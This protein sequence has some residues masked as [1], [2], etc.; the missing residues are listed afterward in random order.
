M[1]DCQSLL[2]ARKAASVSLSIC[3]THI[4]GIDP[5]F[6]NPAQPLDEPTPQDPPQPFA[7]IQY[8][9]TPVVGVVFMDSQHHH[10]RRGEGHHKH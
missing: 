5:Q 1:S 7:V 8:G 10:G 9:F 2:V 3:R 4:P 6:A